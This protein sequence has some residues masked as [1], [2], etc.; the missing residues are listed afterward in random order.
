M[1]REVAEGFFGLDLLLRSTPTQ[2]QLD[3]RAAR[4]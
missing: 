3:Q 2:L 1:T 4:L